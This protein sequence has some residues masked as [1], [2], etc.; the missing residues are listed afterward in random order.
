MLVTWLLAISLTIAGFLAGHFLINQYLKAK[1]PDV[2]KFEATRLDEKN[3]VV[4]YNS[5]TGEFIRHPKNYEIDGLSRKE[6]S[7]EKNMLNF[8]VM[9]SSAL[10]AIGSLLAQSRKGTGV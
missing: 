1:W 6:Y 7:R 4:D 9:F 8:G 3:T 5:A 2:Y 10:I